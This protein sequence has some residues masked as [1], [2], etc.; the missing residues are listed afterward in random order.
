MPKAAKKKINKKKNDTNQKNQS[1]KDVIKKLQEELSSLKEKNIKLL[2]EF[3]NF[4]K[5]TIRE[6]DRMNKYQGFNLIKDFLPIFDDLDRTLDHGSKEESDSI[7]EVI[8]MIDSKMK[9]VLSKYS[10]KAFESL[11]KDFDPN[12]H[13]ALLE[14]ESE[15]IKKGKVLEEYEKGYLYNDKIIRHAKVVV[16]KGKEE[17]WGIFMI[18]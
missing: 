12:F 11:N 6:K 18:Y 1:D 16:S 13:E 10:I 3:D 2:A 7:F 17:K 14:I 5:R 4:Q 8:S 9:T 15:E